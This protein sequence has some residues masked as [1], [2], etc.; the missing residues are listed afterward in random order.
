MDNKMAAAL[1]KQMGRELWSG[2]IYLQMEAYLTD[3]GLPGMG[4]WMRLQYKEEEVHGMMIYGYLLHAGA[5]VEMQPIPEIKGEWDSVLEVWENVLAHEQQVTAWIHELVDLARELDDKATYN[6]L[7]WYVAQQVEEE[8]N[9]QGVID[10]LKFVKSDP[11]S[12]LLMDRE[13]A[14]RTFAPPPEAAEY[15]VI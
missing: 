6:F 12:I 5:K 2:Y 8:A 3:L 10:T 14:G 1:N 11:Q 4:R 13:M 15:G 7:Q 9:A